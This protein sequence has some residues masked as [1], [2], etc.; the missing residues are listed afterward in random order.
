ME[1]VHNNFP[2]ELLNLI[3]QY[4]DLCTFLTLREALLSSADLSFKSY[5]TTA[6]VICL[7][8]AVMYDNTDL[9]QYITQ[10]NSRFAIQKT[11]SR[12]DKPIN[13]HWIVNQSL[14][15]LPVDIA[16]G[17]GNINAV[18]FLYDRGEQPSY[19]APIWSVI[20]GNL[21]MLKYL[22]TI[23]VHIPVTCLPEAC[24]RNHFDIIR[25]LYSIGLKFD[26][27]NGKF[28]I[29]FV[30]E[31]CSLEVLKLLLCLGER[32]ET[33]VVHYV[34]GK[35][36]GIGIIP[37]VDNACVNRDLRV[38][39]FLYSQ[40]YKATSYGMASA[41]ARGH[42]KMIEYLHTKGLP[43]TSLNYTS[44]VHYNN[45]QHLI[46]LLERLCKEQGGIVHE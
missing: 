42:S 40:G 1:Y 27:G 22:H 46:P 15:F 25:F 36:S 13:W 16:C 33:H 35:R 37:H 45:H 3:G 8:A 28:E 9:L 18:K 34:S 7:E 29:Q 31:N 26:S 21:G 20:H 6:G 2:T 39:A 14:S 19:C 41:C 30:F 12:Y 23:N 44:A 11:E 17:Y 4:C 24:F 32:M 38:I 43:I 5:F 10:T